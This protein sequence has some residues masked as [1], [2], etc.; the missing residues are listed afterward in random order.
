MLGMTSL[1]E[2]VTDLC[3]FVA[4]VLFVDNASH[5]VLRQF[6]FPSCNSTEQSIKFY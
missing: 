4:F 1:T 5:Q 2:K 6:P 3:F